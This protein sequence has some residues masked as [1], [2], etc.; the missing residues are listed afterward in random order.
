MQTPTSMTEEN[1][2][3]RGKRQTSLRQLAIIV[4]S[5]FSLIAIFRQQQ[6]FLDLYK[7]LSDYVFAS[8]TATANTTAS[9]QPQTNQKRKHI[10]PINPNN[11]HAKISFRLH[12]PN[13]FPI[14]HEYNQYMR[15][16]LGSVTIG[17]NRNRRPTGEGRSGVLP[18]VFVRNEYVDVKSHFVHFILSCAS[19]PISL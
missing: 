2:S 11:K 18:D 13:I 4:V 15:C 10:R 12:D 3:S 17:K 16:P 5:V 7:P 6:L 14:T 19:H 9:N 1:A 8:V